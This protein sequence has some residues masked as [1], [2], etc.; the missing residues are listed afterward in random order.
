MC[1]GEDAYPRRFPHTHRQPARQN[2]IRGATLP[3]K[4]STSPEMP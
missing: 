1:E 4:L 3:R 2:F